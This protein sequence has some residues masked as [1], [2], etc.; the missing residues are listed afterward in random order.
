M[1]IK[2]VV[3]KVSK[4]QTKTGKQMYSF[5]LG[6]NW[7]SGFEN[8]KVNV[9]D[10]ISVEYHMSQDGQY[11]N[12]EGIEVNKTTPKEELGEKIGLESL[13]EMLFEANRISGLM[14]T[15]L[16]VSDEERL[17]T[18]REVFGQLMDLRITKMIEKFK[19]ARGL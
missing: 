15:G 14:E 12:Y 16:E 9:G 8:P 4:K 19:Q 10:E 18:R 2:G 11:R 17:A 7:Y 5:Q 1:E 6:G 13:D 3:E